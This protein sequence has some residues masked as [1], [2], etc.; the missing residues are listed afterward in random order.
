MKIILLFLSV[1]FSTCLHS[2]SRITGNW[3]G[4][5][6]VSGMEIR[7][8][9]KVKEEDGKLI[10]TMDSPDQGTKDIKVTKT[11]FINDSACFAISGMGKYLGVLQPG[12]TLIK[13]QWKQGGKDFDLDLK[14]VKDIPAL[15][16]PQEPKEPFLYEIKE[17]NFENKKDKVTLAGTITIPKN[18]T[19]VPVVIMITGSGPQNRDEEI[20]GHKPFWVIADYLT[21]NGIAVLRYDDRGIGKSTGNFSTCTSEDFARDAQS[22]VDFLKTYPGIDPKKIGLAGHSEG[23]MIA[24]M[25]AVNDKDVAFIILLA[26]T[27]L[28]GEE[29]LMLQSELIARADSVPENE[30]KQALEINKKIY[31]IVRK[32]KDNTKAAKKIREYFEE[33]KK[34]MTKEEQKEL[35]LMFIEGSIRQVLAPWFRYF[36]SYDPRKLLK[37]VSCPVLAMNGGK[38]LQVPPKENL[39]SIENCLKNGKCKIHKEKEFPGLNH[40]FQHCTTGS[41]SEYSIIEETFAQEVL[42]EM[43]LWILALPEIKP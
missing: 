30:I 37:K 32:N 42:E 15:K 7:L 23:G 3:L 34:N 11:L 31:E 9:I 10:S 39:K 12:D 18:A 1:I 36:L 43:K 13:G 16:R 29:I 21:K 4:T 24:P 40:L 25:V 5:L 33:A 17:I 27:G 20:M 14:K 38:D 41:V 26:G 2:Q 8:V 19:V 6:K 28:T 22:A 35:S